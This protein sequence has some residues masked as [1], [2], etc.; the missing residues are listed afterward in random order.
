VVV[1][2]GGTLA[3]SDNTFAD[4]ALKDLFPEDL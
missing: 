1:D 3:Q 2:K 4:N